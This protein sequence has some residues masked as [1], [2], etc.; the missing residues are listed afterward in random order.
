M[1]ACSPR[2]LA[3]NGVLGHACATPSRIRVT[4][5]SAKATS[6]ARRPRTRP[7]APSR[8]LVAQ[9]P[10]GGGVAAHPGPRRRLL[11]RGEHRRAE[12]LGRADQHLGVGAG[13]AEQGE[14][15]GGRAA[16]RRRPGQR[17]GHRVAQTAGRQR[18]QVGR[19]RRDAELVRPGRWRTGR[20][21]E[22]R[23]GSRGAGRAR[24]SGTR[25]A[26]RRTGRSRPRMGRSGPPPKSC[27]GL[28]YALVASTTRGRCSEPGR[29]RT[30]SRSGWRGGRARS[31]CRA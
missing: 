19:R 23:P 29:G 1:A 16:R 25:S 10:G 11:Q 5:A 9:H 13:L 30:R 27:S 24:T 15:V 2:S 18:V 26:P 12:H 4:R 20:L 7:S 3:S 17:P 31:R 21:V 14:Q 22:R 28:A 8:V 6:T